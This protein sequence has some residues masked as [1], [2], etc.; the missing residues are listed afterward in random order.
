MLYTRNQLVKRTEYYM[1]GLRMG[2]EGEKPGFIDHFIQPLMQGW[3]DGRQQVPHTGTDRQS[4]AG[5]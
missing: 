1:M 5:V 3:R 4:H 2:R